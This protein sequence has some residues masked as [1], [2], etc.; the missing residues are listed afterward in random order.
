M[1]SKRA[2][3]ALLACVFALRAADAPTH[4]DSKREQRY[5]DRL[6]KFQREYLN[7][8]EEFEKWC[9]SHG[10]RVGP[11]GAQ[12]DLGCVASPSQPPVA[13]PAPGRPEDKK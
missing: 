8:T 4:A 1:R 9:A 6:R 3:T 13:A 10:Q 2:V 11:K 5:S 12:G 7:V